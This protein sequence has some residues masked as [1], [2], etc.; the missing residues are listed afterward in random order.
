[1]YEELG[2]IILMRIVNPCRVALSMRLHGEGIRAEKRETDV[3]RCTIF[4]FD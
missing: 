3:L 2:G 1:M 4:P